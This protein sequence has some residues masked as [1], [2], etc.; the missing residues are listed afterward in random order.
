MNCK[1]ILM[2]KIKKLVYQWAII[3]RFRRLITLIV[4]KSSTNCYNHIHMINTGLICRLMTFTLSPGTTGFLSIRGFNC[5]IDIGGKKSFFYSI[6][7]SHITRYSQLQMCDPV[8][9][10]T[11]SLQITWRDTSRKISHH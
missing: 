3:S 1:K 2:K 8:D 9:H 10:I 5:D 7:F 6:F 4:F 11:D